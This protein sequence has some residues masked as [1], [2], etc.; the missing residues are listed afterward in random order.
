[1][2]IGSSVQT[3]G[4]LS[5]FV[6]TTFIDY[7]VLHASLP[8]LRCEQGDLLALDVPSES[9]PSLSCLHV[10]EHV[11]LGRYGDPIDPRGSEK[12]AGEL[13]RVLAQSGTLFLTVPVGRGRV[14][15]NA[16]RVFAPNTVLAMFKGLDLVSFAYVDDCGQF[17]EMARLDQARH[18]DYGCGMFRFVKS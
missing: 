8:G 15:F 14:C 12:A 7:R 9:V 10:I 16:H 13:V 2:D 3:V 6:E 5:G 4:V 1:M 17:H 18:C 11:G